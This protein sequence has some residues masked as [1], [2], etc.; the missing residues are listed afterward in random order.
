M[1]SK[2]ALP[3]LREQ[4]KKIAENLRIIGLDDL[5]GRMD[6]CFEDVFSVRGECGEKKHVKFQ[7]CKLRYCPICGILRKDVLTG[8]YF[9]YLKAMEN[10][11]L[12]TLTV[13]NVENISKTDIKAMTGALSKLRRSVAFTDNISGGF[14]SLEVKKGRKKDMWH[15][16]FHILLDMDI[17]WS[18]QKF[19]KKIKI[20]SFPP[21]LKKV[22]TPIIDYISINKSSIN[23][24][25]ILPHSIMP[26]PDRKGKMVFDFLPA[27]EK[28]YTP[29]Q[30][31]EWQ[32]AK[33]FDVLLQILITQKWYGL[34][35]GY[36]CNLRRTNEMALKELFKYI[37]KIKDFADD[38]K[39]LFDFVRAI[40]GTRL[41]QSFGKYY[42]FN[43]ENELEADFE[44]EV[45]FE[46]H[47]AAKTKIE[48]D[49]DTGKYF[50]RIKC[51]SCV[52]GR[53]HGCNAEICAVNDAMMNGFI[54]HGW[55]NDPL[56]RFAKF[57][58]GFSELKITREALIQRFHGISKNIKYKIKRDKILSRSR[59]VINS[60]TGEIDELTAECLAILKSYNI[61]VRCDMELW[62]Y[63]KALKKWY[64]DNETALLKNYVFGNDN[65]K[66]AQAFEKL[67]EEKIIKYISELIEEN[68]EWV[69][70][71]KPDE[72]IQQYLDY[73]I[74]RD[75]KKNHQTFYAEFKDAI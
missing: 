64:T 38:A 8:K 46:H 51:R 49:H 28:G 31:H 32:E 25:S 17:T 7:V 60:K 23:N 41:I 1:I 19:L 71:T 18:I 47:F 63:R 6:A 68:L 59:G 67:S 75:F 44:R 55:E 62:Y 35:G 14:Y 20:D 66:K 74:K 53:V 4:K 73:S 34:T 40:D 39:Q 9:E 12:L 72:D 45:E 48:K 2:K 22:L 33:V 69:C 10:P 70:D 61:E 43:L 26:T 42:N 24:N 21:N 58:Q 29:D 27:K 56:H 13:P 52:L 36:I 57:Q 11:M 5:A 37:T 50:A 30:R 15:P 65:E 54:R 3:K 16:H